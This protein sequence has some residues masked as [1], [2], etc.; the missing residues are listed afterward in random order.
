[1]STLTRQG[2]AWL[3]ICSYLYWMQTGLHVGG[4]F[5]F[6]GI[7]WLE[8]REMKVVRLVALLFYQKM[9][10]ATFRCIFHVV[11][12]VK[13]WEFF[14]C[15]GIRQRAALLHEYCRYLSGGYFF[16]LLTTWAF[17]YSKQ[18]VFFSSHHVIHS[19]ILFGRACVLWQ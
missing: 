12:H 6:H 13:K 14:L 2:I 10:R 7:S 3:P 5:C 4:V 1:M 15:R 17:L 9:N 16:G 18:L 8:K 11:C 19:N